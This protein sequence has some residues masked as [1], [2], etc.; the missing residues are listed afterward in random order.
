[1]RQD[2][3]TTLK[4]LEVRAAALAGHTVLALADALGV[5][6]PRESRRAKGFV[7]QLA[8]AAL[9]AAANAG[10]GPD[11]PALQVELKTI[12]LL[13]SGRPRESTFCCSIQ[14]ARSDREEWRSSRLRRRLQQV[15]WLPVIGGR[16]TAV[17]LRRFGRATLWRPTP[18]EEQLLCADW[19][20]LMG[21]IAAGR[22][23]SAH[24]GVAL[25]VRPK[26]P[27]RD[28][29]S[30]APGD[31]G[32]RLTLPLGFYLRASFTATI[33]RAAPTSD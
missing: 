30:L 16:G 15:L 14:M 23:P 33:L 12:P 25:Q 22:V 3:P 13:A 5:E 4:E 24:H 6:V 18:V 9:G 19:E 26:A 31:D 11:F 8:E 28:A 17:A 29:R 7:G 1:M 20:D 10:D 32:P 21:R 27:T 2:P